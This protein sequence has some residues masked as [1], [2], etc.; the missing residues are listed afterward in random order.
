MQGHTPFVVDDKLPVRISLSEYAQLDNR[1][2]SAWAKERDAPHGIPNQVDP[3]WLQI[4]RK[5]VWLPVG[6]KVG[7]PSRTKAGPPALE[8]GCRHHD[9]P[10]KPSGGFVSPKPQSG[11]MTGHGGPLGSDV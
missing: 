4:W 2:A 10:T 9:N 6:A 5:I 7:L 11:D 8:F 3:T 1:P